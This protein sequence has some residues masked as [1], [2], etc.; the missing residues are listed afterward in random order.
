MP[1]SIKHY[2]TLD[3]APTEY[4]SWRPGLELQRSTRCPLIPTW[5]TENLVFSAI[6]PARLCTRMVRLYGTAEQI[7]PKAPPPPPGGELDTMD[8]WDLLL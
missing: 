6:L 8:L 2:T 5:N 1:Y 7:P 3:E 4:V